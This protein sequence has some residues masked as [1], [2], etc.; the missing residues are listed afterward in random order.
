MSDQNDTIQPP[1]VAYA[2][3]EPG[4]PVPVL[5]SVFRDDDWTIVGN[6][7]P[8]F[9][10][11]AAAQLE[12][13]TIVRK[14]TAEVKLRSGGGYRYSYATLE[15]TIA[16][17]SEALNKHGLTLTQP[18]SI[19]GGRCRLR[20]N[21]GH[22]SGS[23]MF[24]VSEFPG[25]PEGEREDGKN[26]WQLLG[27]A[28]TYARRYAA[29][30]MLGVAPNDDDDAAS[31]APQQRQQVRS[32]PPNL[33]PQRQQ[34]AQKP[35]QQQAQKPQ[36]APTQPAAQKPAAQPAPASQ[37]AAQPPAQPAPAQQPQP[38][39]RKSTPPPPLPTQVPSNIPP[40]RPAP[41][42]LVDSSGQTTLVNPSEVQSI[43]DGDPFADEPTPVN[44]DAPMT[45][46]QRAAFGNEMRRLK[47][48]APEGFGFIAHQFGWDTVTAKNA[49]MAKEESGK[50]TAAQMNTLLIAIRQIPDP[51][52]GMH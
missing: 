47:W 35:A 17:T 13:E 10:A 29:Q 18:A 48:K 22:S 40:A 43:D 36:A 50:M 7:A 49:L 44:G 19:K 26:P 25:V 28:I 38:A 9:A 51:S 42:E 46:E 1:A 32:T 15:E 21:L 8:L 30:A 45:D 11:L 20:T 52:A 33:P 2:D 12:F 27:S 31:T 3:T 14:E 39:Q 4:T 23:F 16:A 37:P 34:Q 5:L 24:T 41:T 6:P